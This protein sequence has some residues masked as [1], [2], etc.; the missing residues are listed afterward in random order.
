[1]VAEM[2]GQDLMPCNASSASSGPMEPELR[3]LPDFFEEVHEEIGG[4]IE[5]ITNL[6][7]K[8]GVVMSPKDEKP[9]KDSASN[10]PK[11]SPA[12]NEVWR[13]RLRISSARTWLEELTARLE[14]YLIVVATTFLGFV[15]WTWQEKG[16]P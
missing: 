16:P 1:M 4:L 10:D 13:I 8:L 2:T 7:L 9:E 6:E 3:K 15:C 5:A 12:C 11:L 14:L